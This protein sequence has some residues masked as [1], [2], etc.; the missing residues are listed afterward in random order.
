ML[1]SLKRKNSQRST[2]SSSA[3]T[4]NNSWT[5]E[6][7]VEFTI[8]SNDMVTVCNQKTQ[9]NYSEY[10]IRNIDINC[11]LLNDIKNMK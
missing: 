9:R 11:N 2:N 1:T 4:R 7:D 8:D 10:F 3:K 5:R 6:S